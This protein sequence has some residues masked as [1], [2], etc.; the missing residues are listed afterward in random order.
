[1]EKYNGWAN[2]ETWA[3]NL[4]LTNEIMMDLSEMDKVELEDEILY[5]LDQ[6]PDASAFSKMFKDILYQTLNKV[7]YQEIID[8]A[9]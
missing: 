8:N 6:I 1:M 5:H 4:W 7:D 2:Y 3:V 9:K